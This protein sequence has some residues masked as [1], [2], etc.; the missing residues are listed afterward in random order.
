M[1]IFR[2]K[3]NPS[4]GDVSPSDTF[5]YCLDN[6]VLGIGWDVHEYGLAAT[7]NWAEYEEKAMQ[8]Y[9][10]ISS[11][12]YLKSN[13]AENDLV[14]TRGVGDEHAG[15]HFLARIES[16]WEYY[17]PSLAANGQRYGVENIFRCA[18]IYEVEADQV[19]GKV[20]SSFNGRGN[21]M[22][23]V[24]GKPILEYS[25]DLW[26][27]F[28]GEEFYPVDKTNMTLF[29]ML[30]AEE[31][32]DVLFLYLQHKGWRV[33]PHSRKGGTMKFEF[34]AKCSATGELA[35]TQ[36]KVG[37]TELDREQY[38][39]DRWFLWQLNERYTGADADNVT[40]ITRN[41]IRDFIESDEK[42][43]PGWL[44]NQRKMFGFE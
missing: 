43:L 25:K 21:V 16:G 32:E 29:D 9:D 28:L 23:R 36:V 39:S 24:T 3:I 13:V 6:N 14:W 19:P 41:E 42:W 31:A 18:S 20:V 4:G 12:K 8:K 2:I 22:Q 26:N 27:Q 11:V 37:D 35:H 7:Q 1:N 17:D 40:C 5:Q 15:K 34:L 30:D 33:I 10:N 44:N 38:K